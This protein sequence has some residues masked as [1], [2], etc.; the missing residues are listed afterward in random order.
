MKNIFKLF[1]TLTLVFSFTSC[2]EDLVIFDADNGQTALS[3]ASSAVT[4][5]VCEPTVDLTV[6]STT[7]SSSDRTYSITVNA[8][9][10]AVPAEYTIGNSVTIPAGQHLG[11]IPVTVDFAQVPI[12]ENRE[13][14][15]DLVA[16]DGAVIN[17]RGTTTY[18]YTSA[19]TLNEVV[20]DLNFDQFPEEMAYLIF[21][22][23]S[24]ALV[25]ASFNASGAPAF[26][27]FDGLTSFSKTLCLPDGDYQVQFLD[28]WG[29]GNTG[30][31]NGSY[32]LISATCAGNT[33]IFTPVVDGGFGATGSQLG[34]APFIVNFTL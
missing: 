21:D 28:S 8:A 14:I 24:G 20:V 19:C 31:A 32:G 22:T 6:E 13:L 27:T 1:L 23:N 2:E 4:V 34:T 16:S 26:G 18:S 12:G 17:T 3:F 15:L 33:D 7:Q 29:D 30:N 25:D 10:T 11:T 9:S 5:G